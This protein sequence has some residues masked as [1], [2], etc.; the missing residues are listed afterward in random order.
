M[1]GCVTV[2]LFPVPPTSPP[3]PSPS[4]PSPCTPCTPCT[5]SSLAD[6]AH[7]HDHLRLPPRRRAR[8]HHHH[9]VYLRTLSSI[10]EAATRLPRPCTPCRCKPRTPILQEIDSRRHQE[11]QPGCTCPPRPCDFPTSS[12]S[13]SSSTLSRSP[14]M[15]SKTM[16]RTASG[17]P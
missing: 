9:P 17:R 14:P 16:T 1:R 2:F 13:H 12:L 3:S 5:P 6:S 8:L 11:Q 10:L 7:S 15:R 4:P